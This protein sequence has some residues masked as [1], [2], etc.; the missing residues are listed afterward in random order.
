MRGQLIWPEWL[1]I[2]LQLDFLPSSIS[3][4]SM[5]PQYLMCNKNNLASR[6]EMYRK[7]NSS[8]H[9]SS[10]F[11]ISVILFEFI[12]TLKRCYRVALVLEAFWLLRNACFR[13]FQ[14]LHSNV[15][16]S[17]STFN[18]GKRMYYSLQLSSYF[19]QYEQNTWSHVK[20]RFGAQYKEFLK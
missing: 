20:K 8:L 13:A 7:K 11:W 10:F 18:T 17:E 6:I 3:F 16:C 2:I 1:I 9:S 14:L 19:C 4:Q 15:L 12:R 5:E